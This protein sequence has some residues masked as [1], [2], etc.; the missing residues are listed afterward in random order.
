M[1][2]LPRLMTQD[3]TR[4]PNAPKRLVSVPEEILSLFR[5]KK[6]MEMQW[7]FPWLDDRYTIKMDLWE[8]LVGRS[9]NKRGWLADDYIDIWIEYLWHFRNTTLYYTYQELVYPLR[10]SSTKHCPD[11]L[12]V[13]K[14]PKMDFPK[15]CRPKKPIILDHKGRNR[16]KSQVEEYEAAYNN[17]N[18]RSQ[19]YARAN[20][21][22]YE[23]TQV[24]EYEAAYNNNNERS[25]EYT[26]ANNNNYRRTQEHEYEASYNNNNERSQEYTGANNNNYRRTQ[27]HEYEASYNNNN[28]RS[29]EY[30]RAYNNNYGRTQEY[31]YE[32][33]YNKNN[34]RSHE[35]AGAYNN[36]YMRT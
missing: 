22:N 25:Q 36:N 10:E 8:R 34:R 32:T 26:G 21:N 6:K 15:P 5:D 9:A 24:E 30:A 1:N 31:E 18:E 12:P 28:E 35:Y 16:Y 14:P 13:F 2:S 3:L 20:N 19:E 23:R 29:Q 27:E 11:G 4:S 17:K 7:T 33:T